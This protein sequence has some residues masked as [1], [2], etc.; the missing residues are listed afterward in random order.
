MCVRCVC[1]CVQVASCSEAA[2][3]VSAAYTKRI[4]SS[5]HLSRTAEGDGEGPSGLPSSTAPSLPST[6]GPGS[7]TISPDEEQML[8]RKRLDQHPT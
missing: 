2:S 6:W 4:M 7:S 1:A 8:K 3:Q 5:V